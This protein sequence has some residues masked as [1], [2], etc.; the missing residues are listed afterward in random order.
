[1]IPRALRKSA[2]FLAR[3]L[4]LALDDM[5]GI[6]NKTV[7]KM[8]PASA[9]RKARRMLAEALRLID[10]NSPDGAARA[11]RMLRD[12]AMPYFGTADLWKIGTALC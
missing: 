1:M 12:V 6:I 7:P 11:G 9:I 3:Q 10:R 2:E 4:A 8:T 5:T